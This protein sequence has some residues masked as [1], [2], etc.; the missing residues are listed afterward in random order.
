MDATTAGNGPGPRIMEPVEKNVVLASSDQVA[1]DAVAAK[2]MGF[3]PMQIGY[4]N[5]AHDEG[6]GVGDPREIELVGDD[7]SNESWG[8]KVGGHLHSFLGWLTW[9]GPTKVLQKVVT[10]PPVVAI[11]ILFSE[12]FH[13]YYHWPLKEKKVYERWLAESQWG[14]LFA[15]YA[16][17]GAQAPSPA[18]S[19]AA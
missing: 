13:D 6:L 17:E 5:I 19:T 3:D 15:K 14:R 2:M 12:V 7:I 4:I 11:P 18:P 10:R 8:F 1:I 16:S 9:Y